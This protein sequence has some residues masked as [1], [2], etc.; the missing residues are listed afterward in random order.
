MGEPRDLKLDRFLP[1]L[2][3]NRIGP[4]RFLS[5]WRRWEKLTSKQWQFRIDW[6]AVWVDKIGAFIFLF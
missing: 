1:R 2:I 4:C 6:V 5:V 3:L